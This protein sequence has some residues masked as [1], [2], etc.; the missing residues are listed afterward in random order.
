MEAA[1]GQRP[2]P[3]EADVPT[4]RDLGPNLRFRTITQIRHYV[5]IVAYLVRSGLPRQRLGASVSRPGDSRSVSSW[6]STATRAR[7]SACCRLW[8]AQNSSSPDP[9]STT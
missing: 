2:D 8:C 6:I 9:G 7:A 4:P 3:L 5:D 1:G